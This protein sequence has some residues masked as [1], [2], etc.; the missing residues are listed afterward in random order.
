MTFPVVSSTP[1]RSHPNNG[2]RF[3]TVVAVLSTLIALAGCGPQQAEQAAAEAPAVG[4]IEITEQKVNPFFEFVGKTLPKETVALRARV[5]GFLEERSFAEGG[6]VEVGQVLFRIEPEQYQATVAQAE[7]A[8]AAAK[9]KLNQ[10]QVDLARYQELAKKNNVSKQKVDEAAALVL[11]EEATV[12]T[13][14]AD[15]RKTRLDL[16]YTEITAPIGGRID[17]AAYDVGNLVGPDSGVMATI[18]LMDPID[19]TFSISETWY[20]ELA[21]A[22]IEAERAGKDVDEWTHIP[23]I[24]LP[25]GRRYEYEGDFDFVDNKVDQKTGTVLIRAQFPNPDQ[26]LLPG[27]FVTV[28]IE[29]KQALDA[30]VVPQA[31]VL[32]DQAGYYVL[33][34]NDEDKV[35][36]R[37]IE[38]GQRFGANWVVKKGLSVGERIILY[39]IQKVR[40]GLTV[41]PEPATAPEDPMLQGAS[42]DAAEPVAEAAMGDAAADDVAMADA[43]IDEVAAADAA[44]DD[45]AVAVDEGSVDDPGQAAAPEGEEVEVVTAEDDVDEETAPAQDEPDE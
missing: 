15:L 37:R 44:G 30:V 7:A 9:A 40:P 32:T 38:T 16:Q 12:E 31:A 2:V 14:E 8:L 29:R 36:S 27:Q 41:K 10:A 22:D 20:L 28:I 4:V 3:G 33:L 42:A 6:K 25:N 39:G 35:E 13:A 11:V 19:V 45:A 21:E 17:L 5:T 18:N 1:R 26:L 34:V 24:K 43:A 23:L